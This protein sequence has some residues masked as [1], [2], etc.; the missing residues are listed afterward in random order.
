[1][2]KQND[3][4]NGSKNVAEMIIEPVFEENLIIC[5]KEID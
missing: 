2:P 1:M 3:P 4:K 5:T